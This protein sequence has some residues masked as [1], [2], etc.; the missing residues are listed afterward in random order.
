MIENLNSLDTKLFLYLNGKHNAFFDPIMY[1][2]SDKLFWIP[3]YTAIAALLIWHYKKR[4]IPIFLAIGILI[5]LA[6]QIASHLIKHTVKRLRPSHNSAL[7][8]LIHLSKAGPGGQ[9]G[10]VSS[11]AANAFAL[12]A[13]LFFILP[14]KFNWLKWILGFWALLVSYS[15]IYNGVHYPGDVIIAALVGIGLGYLMSKLYFFYKS[16]AEKQF[17]NV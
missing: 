9:Y 6:D 17:S 3:F 8:G 2:A 5:T 13:F 10:F 1:W 4:S 7:E 14:K 11:H 16:K 12:A 15:R